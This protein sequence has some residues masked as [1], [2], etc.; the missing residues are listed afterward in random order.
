MDGSEAEQ[1][2]QVIHIAEHSFRTA[3][4]AGLLAK[5]EGAAPARAT[6]PAVWHDT[7]ETRVLDI[8]RLGRKYL[9]AASNDSVTAEQVTGL[10]RGCRRWERA[11]SRI[12]GRREPRGAVRK[13]RRQGGV[14]VPGH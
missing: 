9:E 1:F 10:P 5:A 14:P 4:I 12:R 11:G 3:I 6:Y 7:R 8:P 13:R 2:A